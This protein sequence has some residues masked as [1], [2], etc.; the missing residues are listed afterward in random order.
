M[1]TGICN[2]L[3]CPLFD[4]TDL[5]GNHVFDD[6][7]PTFANVDSNHGCYDGGPALVASTTAGTGMRVIAD[8]QAHQIPHTEPV[9]F[10]FL[11]YMRTISGTPQLMNSG[12]GA[13][14]SNYGIQRQASAG[15]RH[16]G[17][18][19]TTLGDHRT[20]T[21]AGRFYHVCLA[22]EANRSSSPAGAFYLNGQEAWTGTIG[23]AQA[24]SSTDDFAFTGDADETNSSWTGFMVNAFVTDTLLD[25]AT[26]KNLSDEA[27]GHASPLMI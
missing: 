20:K 4:D 17:S 2:I 19:V 14:N 9:T 25:P 8:S 11:I 13:N 1:D 18:G 6:G 16:Q 10:G 27:F 5:T 15:W 21:P 24:V 7:T 22:I 23:N 12:P 3:C 26:I